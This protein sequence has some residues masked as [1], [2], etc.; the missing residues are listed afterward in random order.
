LKTLSILNLI[1]ANLEVR[2]NFIFKSVSG[3][4]FFISEG[5][6]EGKKGNGKYEFIFT[7]PVSFILKFESKDEMV[8]LIGKKVVEEKSSSILSRFGPTLMIVVFFVV[9]KFIRSSTGGAI[10]RAQ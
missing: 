6:F 9:S 4:S 7:S 2:Q 3:D 1:L 8:R 5:N 10:Q